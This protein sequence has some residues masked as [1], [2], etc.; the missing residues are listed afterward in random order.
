MQ[1][2]KVHSKTKQW[3]ITQ[4]EEEEKKR[5]QQKGKENTYRNIQTVT[6]CI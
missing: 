3:K 2:K 6:Y 1:K 5:K 4:T